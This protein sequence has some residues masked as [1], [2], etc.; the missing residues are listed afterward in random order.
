MKAEIDLVVSAGGGVLTGGVAETVLRA[1]L[2]G[3]LVV[4]LGNVLALLDL[5]EASAGLLGHALEGTFCRQRALGRIVAAVAATA[6]ASATGVAATTGIAATATARVAATAAGVAT[7][8]ATTTAVLRVVLVG[9]FAFEVNGVDDRVGALGGLDGFDEGLSAAAV[10]AVGED[11]DGLASGLLA[12]EL[13]GGE[14]EGV[15]EDGSATAAGAVTTAAV[16][17]GGGIACA[18]SVDLFEGR[19]KQRAGQDEGHEGAQS[20]R[21]T[22]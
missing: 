12:H 3:D 17:R 21:R 16:I 19:L 22:A 5:E 9:F 20:R 18:G 10:T 15:E 2:L 14:E 7:R 1:Q 4:D 8:V 6:V 11:D 13:V